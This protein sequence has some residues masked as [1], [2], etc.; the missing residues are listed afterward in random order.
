MDLSEGVRRRPKTKLAVFGGRGDG[1]GGM[2]LVAAEPER[3]EY[4]GCGPNVGHSVDL[5]GLYR[6]PVCMAES[7][8]SSARVE[9]DRNLFL[10]YRFEYGHHTK[11]VYR[12]EPEAHEHV[13]C[14][15]V[16][17]EHEQ[18]RRC[19]RADQHADLAEA[20]VPK[21]NI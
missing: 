17:E 9:L 19:T 3:P 10:R 11:E 5:W 12:G 4:E 21:P 20:Q 13:H 1:S 8:G 6:G 16:R 7:R 18:R 15:L 2:Y 14:V